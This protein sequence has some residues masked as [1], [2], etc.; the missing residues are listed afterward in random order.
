VL[1]KDELVEIATEKHNVPDADYGKMKKGDLV[2][3]MADMEYDEIPFWDLVLT[4]NGSGANH[5]GAYRP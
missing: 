4:N 1:S 5:I 3:Y 2:T